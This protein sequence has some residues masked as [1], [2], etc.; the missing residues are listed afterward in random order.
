MVELYRLI[1]SLNSPIT[2][3]LDSHP[4]LDD[5]SW[6]ASLKASPHPPRPSADS[7]AKTGRADRP[8]ANHEDE[9]HPEKTSGQNEQ[10]V[11][12]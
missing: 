11:R 6:S 8:S 5:K 10:V 12:A 1:G 4:N 9:F 3:A 2:P 7:Y